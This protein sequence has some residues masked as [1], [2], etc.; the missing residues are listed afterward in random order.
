MPPLPE[1][2]TSGQ[3]HWCDPRRID[4]DLFLG[5]LSN[6]YGVEESLDDVRT[7]DVLCVA[8]V[9]SHVRSPR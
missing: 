7:E 2:S 8:L 5:Y 6:T 1:L 9:Q 4:A 3:R